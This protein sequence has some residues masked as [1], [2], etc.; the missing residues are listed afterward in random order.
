MPD[1][2]DEVVELCRDLIRFESVNDGTGRG[3]GEREAAEYVA[4]KL[5]EVGLEP[6]IFESAPG[7]ASVVARI[8]GEDPSRDALLIHGHLDVV[9]AEPKEWT[10]DP[11]AAEVADGCVWGRGA[12]DMKDM[13]AMVLSIV[14]D[15]MRTGRKP[16]RDVVLAFVA[17]EE[18][19][20]TFGAQLAR[21][22]PAGAVRGLHR[23]DQRGRRVLP[24]SVERRRPALPD[25]DRPEGHGLDAAHRRGHRRPRLDAQRRQRGDPRCARRSRGSAG[26]SSRSTSPRRCGASSPRS[27]TRSASSSTRRPRA[28]HVA[29]SA[30][31]RASSARPC[32][33]PP[34]RRCST[35]ATS[36]TSSRAGPRDGRRAVPA[37]LRGGVGARA[38]RGA[39][40]RHHPRVRPLRHRARDRVRG[41]A[42]RRDGRVAQG[43][44]PGRPAGPVRAVRRHGREELQPAG[45]P[46]VRLRAAAAA[47]GPG[48]LRHVPRRRRAGAARRRCSS[49]YACW[50]GSSTAC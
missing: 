48:L 28:G 4:G 15:R 27:A 22:Q 41:R 11:F 38:R 9:P 32:A 8:E 10:Y 16:P 47:A 33:T 35:P 42:R 25:R 39:R 20:G 46:R 43:R 24:D 2:Q 31:W 50:T 26:T 5:A 40:P 6:Q 37:R 7:R 13:D 18:A 21:R 23:G 14:R 29:C 36:T 19:G 12:V 45:H 3:P 17:D 1:P 30:R 49:A 34:T 44:G